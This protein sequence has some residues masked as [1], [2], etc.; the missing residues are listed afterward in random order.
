MHCCI[1]MSKARKTSA[2]KKPKT[3]SREDSRKESKEI[4]GYR[5]QNVVVDT[6]S[7]FV[8][9][10]RLQDCTDFLLTLGDADVHDRRE[11]PSMNEKYIIDAKKYGVR[12]N[13]QRVHIR[14]EEVISLSLLDDVI[15]Y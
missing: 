10:G 9:I 4:L 15:E 8:F 13:R 7:H 12:R 14:L 6:T 11:S 3:G 2:E 1:A 5:D